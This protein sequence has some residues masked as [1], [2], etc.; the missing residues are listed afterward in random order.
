M[1][2]RYTK[3]ISKKD[4]DSRD[5]FILACASKNYFANTLQRTG[6]NPILWTTNLMAPEAY[7]LHEAIEWRRW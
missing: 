3:S 2:F 1:D 4:D 5:V 6:A 7:I